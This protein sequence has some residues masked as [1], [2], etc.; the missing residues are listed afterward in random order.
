MAVTSFELVIVV[1][2]CRVE[3]GFRV[4]QIEKIKHISLL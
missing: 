4:S 2:E 3:R 1:T